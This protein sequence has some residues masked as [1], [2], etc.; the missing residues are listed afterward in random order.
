M[1]VKISKFHQFW[2]K[3]THWEYWPFDLV[4]FPVK[5]YFTW[6]ALKNRSFFFFTPS[7]PSIDFG[8]ML[9]ESKSKIF[10]L[11][12]EKFL[13]EMKLIKA[14]DL[15]SAKSFASQM[16]YPL[17][18][19][20]DI[21]E[22][23]KLVEK[24]GNE[25]AL[26]NYTSKCPVDFLIQELVDYPVELGV[27]Y[28]RHPNDPNGKVT[29]IV[30][31]DFLTVKGDGHSTVRQL[32]EASTRAKL[33]L[34]F[35]HPRFTHL[36]DLIPEKGTKQLVESI[37][38]HCRGTTFL[39]MN[40]EIDEKL[41][42][43]IDKLSQQIDGF[44]FGRYDL[45]CKSIDDLRQLQNFKILELNGAGA[46]PGHIYQ[47]GFSLL[48]AYGVLFWHF[49]MLSE[50]SAAH[51]KKGVPHWSFSSGMQKLKEIKA[52]NKLIETSRAKSH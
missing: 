41:N 36:M 21:G 27:F 40:A 44:Y 3:L 46:E 43:A 37:G 2:V 29:S 35:D 18:C 33:Q 26:I 52:Y 10:N 24:I 42:Q 28:V 16:G 32:L 19:K 13:P 48:K 6:L 14:G 25:E 7:N 17:I 38:N 31:K 39:N 45:R 5:I 23:G 49:R 8:G 47:P 34:D 30:Q 50:I 51:R 22:R 9:G 15:T 4:Y 12:P 11:I 1:P 20:P